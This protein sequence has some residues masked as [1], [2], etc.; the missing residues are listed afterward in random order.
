MWISIILGDKLFVIPQRDWNKGLSYLLDT[1][2]KCEPINGRCPLPFSGHGFLK[3]GDSLVSLLANNL[4]DH[5][6]S[7]T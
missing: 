1:R 2:H 3:I 6:G 7:R 5:I 4:I